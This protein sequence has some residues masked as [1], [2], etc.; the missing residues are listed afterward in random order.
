MS[1]PH[2]PAGAPPPPPPAGKAILKLLLELGPLLLFFVINSRKGPVVDGVQQSNIIQATLW[3]LVAVT[4]AFPFSWWLER[5]L[6][7]MP[8]VTALFVGTFGGLT[9]LL[10]DST[11]IKLKPT[12]ASLFFAAVL[13]VGLLRGKVLLAKLLG[14]AMSLDPQGWRLLT[15]RWIGFFVGLAALNEVVWRTVSDDAWVTFKV[16]GIL[17]LTFV[18]AALQVPLMKRHELKEE[19]TA[20]EESR[21]S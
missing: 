13:L 5:K 6:P 2:P 14:Q 9:V 1:D 21:P 19:A 18:F 7:V 11:F 17:P 8:L 15:I 12:V 20:E 10:G 3:F 16:W 4:I